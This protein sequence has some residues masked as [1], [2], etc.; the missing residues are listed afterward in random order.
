MRPSGE[1]DFV[2]SWF[3]VRA[4]CVSCYCVSDDEVATA[5]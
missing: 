2:H 1:E 4:Q 5:R 3:I